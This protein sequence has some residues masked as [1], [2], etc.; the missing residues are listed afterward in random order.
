MTE[1]LDLT[2][3]IHLADNP[4]GI[5]RCSC[6]SAETELI[7]ICQRYQTTCTSIP[8]NVGDLYS[9]GISVDNHRICVFCYAEDD[10]YEKRPPDQI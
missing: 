6:P 10:G 9:F 1:R 8:V 4:V 5:A 7:R 3:C 2:D